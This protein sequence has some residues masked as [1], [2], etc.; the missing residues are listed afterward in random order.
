MS[1]NPRNNSSNYATQIQKFWIL[2]SLARMM[3]M[4]DPC[5]NEINYILVQIT[6]KMPILMFFCFNS[7]NK[8]I[9]IACKKLMVS[10]IMI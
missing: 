1:Q 6:N 3:L 5:Q 8:K 10:Y 4:H 2:S 7:C 9:K